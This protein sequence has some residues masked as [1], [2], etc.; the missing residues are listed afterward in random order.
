MDDDSFFFFGE[1]CFLQT[2]L[3]GMLNFKIFSFFFGVYISAQF[4][5]DKLN[6]SAFLNFD[7]L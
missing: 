7:L 5:F 2:L 1:T 6:E 4:D 3:K